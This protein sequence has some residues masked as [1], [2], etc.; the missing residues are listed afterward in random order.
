VAER[1]L[2]VDDEETRRMIISML[3]APVDDCV[4]VADDDR[5]KSLLAPVDYDYRQAG[6][7]LEAMKILGSGETFDLVLTELLV[8]KLGGMRLLKY[9]KDLSPDI[10]VVMVT[11][12][13][14]IQI[15]LQAFHYGAY[16]YLLKPFQRNQLVATVRRALEH[17][18]LKCETDTYR[19]NLE[20]LVAARTQQWK[21]A[22]SDLEKE[23]A[24]KK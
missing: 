1:I 6:D 4:E 9:T 2:I 14:Q 7:G 15:A 22:L 12:S 8:P 5:L 11:A 18:R 19:T 10:E 23:R 24:R 16:D 3:H 20:A 17:R 21:T 13:H